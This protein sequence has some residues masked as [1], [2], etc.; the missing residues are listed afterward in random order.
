MDEIRPTANDV[1]REM[2]DRFETEFD[3]CLAMATN[4]LLQEALADAKRRL[5]GP[6]LDVEGPVDDG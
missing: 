4:R 1:I 3:L 2:R 6:D 5:E